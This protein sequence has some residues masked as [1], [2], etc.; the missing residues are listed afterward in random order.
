M[1]VRVRMSMAVPVVPVGAMMP[2]PRVPMMPMP[3]VPIPAV[4][5]LDRLDQGVAD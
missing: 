1:P 4:T 5:D 2:M 3:G